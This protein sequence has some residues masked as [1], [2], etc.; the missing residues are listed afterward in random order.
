[1]RCEVTVLCWCGE[2]NALAWPCCL[3]KRALLCLIIDGP[4]LACLHWRA[5]SGAAGVGGGC[6][7][8][9]TAGFDGKLST[10][11]TLGAAGAL[12]WQ[13]APSSGYQASQSHHPVIQWN[14]N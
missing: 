14:S 7:L 2:F 10:A 6:W 3:S 13:P 9:V 4:R 8:A 12:A 11:T 1:M 5:Q